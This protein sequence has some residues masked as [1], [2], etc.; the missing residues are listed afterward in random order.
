MGQS[1]F[2]IECTGITIDVGTGE[3][4]GARAPTFERLGQNAPLHASKLQN[5]PDPLANVHVGTGS[6]SSWKE[7]YRFIKC[8][9]PKQS[10]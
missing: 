7:F 5:F 6:S 10:S 3:A 2:I 1:A 9:I 8:V 4:Q